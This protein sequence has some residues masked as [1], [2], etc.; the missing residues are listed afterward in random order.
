MNPLRDIIFLRKN[1]RDTLFFPLTA[2]N[3]VR[4]LDRLRETA[5]LRRLSYRTEQSYI[6]WV[7]QYI[8]FNS[9]RHPR[10][11]GAGEVE[12]FLTH[13]AVSRGVSASTQNQAL[14]ALLFLYR[15]VLVQPLGDLNAMRARRTRYLPVVLSREEAAAIL[16][17]MHGT[18]RLVAALQY[19]G[20]LRLMEALRIRVKDLEFDR[21]IV[22]VR[23]GKGGKDRAAPLPKRLE[24]ELNVHLERVRSLHRADLEA[25]YGSVEL[26][27]AF[28]RKNPAASRTWNWQYVFPAKTL[29]AD[30]RSGEV[31]RHHASETSI[32]RALAEAATQA[33]ITK[34]VG[35]HALRHSFATHLLEDGYD[36]RTVQELLGHS[37]VR[38]TMI[39]T[40]VLNRGGRAVRSPFDAGLAGDAALP[41]AV[42]DHAR[43]AAPLASPSRGGPGRR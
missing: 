15:W 29:S 8:L 12:R 42:R 19:G 16:V 13:L 24:P 26:P 27:F 2:R 43:D 23:Q 33:G 3:Q 18:P 35:T 34:R 30:P 37:D 1:I 9:R 20:G 17:R 41:F 32:Q 4:L 21:S 40:H 14:A 22:V 38:T 28:A 11:M 5:R 10:E 6:R 39:Y 25:G 36:I 31:R 7:R